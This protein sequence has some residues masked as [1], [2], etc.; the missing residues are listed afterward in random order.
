MGVILCYSWF[1]V[2][3]GILKAARFTVVEESAKS[4]TISEVSGY[5]TGFV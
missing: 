4:R 5:P 3:P 2:I 1:D